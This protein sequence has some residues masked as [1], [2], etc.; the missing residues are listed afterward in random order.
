MPK[1]AEV[2]PIRRLISRSRGLVPSLE[3]P[4]KVRDSPSLGLK[5]KV[6]LGQDPLAI[7]YFADIVQRNNDLWLVHHPPVSLLASGHRV[8]RGPHSMAR[9]HEIEGFFVEFNPAWSGKT[10]TNSGPNRYNAPPDLI[11]FDIG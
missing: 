3:V 9:A 5:I 6:K 7:E 11:V 1:R 4:C 10:A 8:E 2:S